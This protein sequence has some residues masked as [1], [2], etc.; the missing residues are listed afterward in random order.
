MNFEQIITNTKEKL[1]KKEKSSD[2]DLETQSPNDKLFNNKILNQL[3]DEEFWKD[4]ANLK[5]NKKIPQK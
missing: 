1:T 5:I 4:C 2:S 3:E